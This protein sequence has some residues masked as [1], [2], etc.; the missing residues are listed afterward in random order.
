MFLPEK[1]MIVV[2][3][4]IIQ[5][6]AALISLGMVAPAFAAGA[7]KENARPKIQKNIKTIKNDDKTFK[8][9]KRN[10]NCSNGAG[11]SQAAPTTIVIDIQPDKSHKNP[12]FDPCTGTVRK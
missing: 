5:L 8:T 9:P 3:K 10:R 12:N 1:K 4:R 7:Q 11:V 6:V 2:N